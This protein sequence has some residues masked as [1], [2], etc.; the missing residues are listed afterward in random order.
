MLLSAVAGTIN[1]TFTY[2]PNGNQTAGLGRTHYY[3][4]FN[5][6]NQI[7][8][9]S[10]YQT[11]L[12]DTEHVRFWKATPEGG[13]LYFDAFGVHC[14][15]QLSSTWTWYDYVSAGGAMVAMRVAYGT[16]PLGTWPCSS[17]SV[18]WPCSSA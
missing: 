13:T 8:Q 18:Y 5:K 9:G 6:P 10:V 7:W 1:S 3:Y 4:S 14:E 12:Y 2:D 16:A 11:F 15:L 17:K